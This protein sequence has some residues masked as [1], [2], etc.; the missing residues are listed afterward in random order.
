[1]KIKC[2]QC[3]AQYNIDA[4]KISSKGAKAKCTKC[5]NVFVIK[6]KSPQ[7]AAT[8]P[9]AKPP[10]PEAPRTPEPAPTPEAGDSA[11]PSGEAGEGDAGFG[12][13]GFDDKPV[14]KDDLSFGDDIAGD[15]LDVP[16]QKKTMEFCANCG[17]TFEK[18]I[19]SAEIYCENCR[20]TGPEEA[21]T[22]A[23]TEDER[24]PTPSPS[25]EETPKTSEYVFED[26][27]STWKVK[28]P[29]GLVYGPADLD[30]IKSWIE[31]ERVSPDDEASK[32][33]G[34]Y[35]PAHTFPQ[36]AYL[37]GLPIP[38]DYPEEE[39]QKQEQEPAEGEAEK[40][41][42]TPGEDLP[43]S[44]V[45]SEAPDE[46]AP[47]RPA[48]AAAG[49]FKVSDVEFDYDDDDDEESFSLK[50]VL[51]FLLIPILLAGAGFSIYNFALSYSQ[52]E[53]LLGCIGLKPAPGVGGG[54]VLPVQIE[55]PEE[56]RP[57][58]AIDRIEES[59]MEEA[60]KALAFFL[61]DTRAGYSNAETLFKNRIAENPNRADARAR[62]VIAMARG[63]RLDGIKLPLDDAEEIAMEAKI[64]KPKSSYLI[65]V[66]LATVFLFKEQYDRSRTLVEKLLKKHPDSPDVLLLSA[67]LDLAEERKNAAMAELSKAL[68]ADPAYQR[69]R[70]LLA[71][72]HAEA[73]HIEEARALLGKLLEDVPEHQGARELAEKIGREAKPEEGKKA[74]EKDSGKPPPEEPKRKEPAEA[75]IKP[76]SPEPTKAEKIVEPESVP[77]ETAPTPAKPA[78]LTTDEV[79]VRIKAAYRQYK[80]G[81]LAE[82]EAVLRGVIDKYPSGG[83][84]KNLGTAYYWLAKI[85][86]KAGK[87]EDAI[88]QVKK[89]IE[90]DPENRK[91]QRLL[92]KLEAQ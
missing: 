83:G 32:N 21:R 29:M 66:S 75:K 6:I 91:A 80:E 74:V 45:P 68:E 58:S 62:L 71:E 60:E 36:L 5:G 41:A 18:E 37:M 72:L 64:G 12:D 61:I 7:E 25:E 63:A 49:G 70:Y 3:G 31:N 4:S 23:D 38:E 14:K 81:Q 54:L 13:M 79:R 67:E 20:D 59:E 65:D 42:E 89:L 17:N 53:V 87:K 39:E 40:P 69:V 26:D 86:A 19:G 22:P 1:M 11:S 35:R 8:P 46:P 56:E 77:A 2:T 48:P 27:G 30:T 90:I 57:K 43:A 10:E 78:R 15:F 51:I 9:A 24:P 84:V 82:A 33:D 55:T 88:E 85:L 52:K 34:A 92:D 28:K 73:G 47:R 50:R 16:P 44:P 76:P